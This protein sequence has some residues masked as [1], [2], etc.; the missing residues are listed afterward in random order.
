MPPA[1]TFVAASTTQNLELPMSLPGLFSLILSLPG[2]RDWLKLLLLGSIF[3]TFRRFSSI[4]WS[5][6]VNSFF[7]TAQFKDEDCSYDWMM[8]WLAKQPGWKIAREVEISTSNFGLNTS[9]IIVPGEDCSALTS[10]STRKLAYLPSL[11]ATYSIWHK[12]RWMQISRTQGQAAFYGRAENTLQIS[13]MTRDHGFLNNL[14]LEAKREYLAAEE[15]NISIFISDST[16]NWRH[17]ASRP[18]RPMASIVLDPGIKDLLIDDAKDFLGSKTWYADRGIPFRRGYLLYGAPGSGKTSIIHSLAG[19]L[20]L[21]VYVIS[22][23]RA[24]LDDSALAELIS[25]LPERCIALMEDIDAAFASEGGLERRDLSATVIDPSG[26]KQTQA[27]SQPP[28]PPV[29]GPRS[30]ASRITLSGL[31]NAIDGIGAHDGRLLYATTNK[32]EALDQALSRPG[33]MDIH[34]EFKLASQWQAGEMFKCFYLPGRVADDESAKDSGYSSPRSGSPRSPIV[35]LPEAE[36]MALVL[37]TT[38]IPPPPSDTPT[39]NGNSHRDRAPTLS[40]R[41]VNDLA[42]EFSGHIPEREFSMAALQGYLMAYK[43]RPIEAAKEVEGWAERQRA[44]K[45]E[46][47]RSKYQA[48]SAATTVK[49]VV[50]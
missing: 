23:S 30:T 15:H 26:E 18:K 47:T 32:Y 50:A 48:Q 36:E 46:K 7:I 12:R 13:I 5:S 34:V 19:E 43:V 28:P 37:S 14:L 38:N 9:A 3:E 29:S 44:E 40:R 6:I 33:R 42:I 20:G 2:L 11:S 24:G 41:Q 1:A 4:I 31:L 10:Q 22:L 35:D 49:A 17:V 8:V 27:Q 21:D 25:D 39:F 45:A 16:N